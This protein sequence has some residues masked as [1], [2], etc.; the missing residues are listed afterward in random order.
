MLVTETATWLLILFNGSIRT[1]VE[2]RLSCIL[3]FHIF[4]AQRTYEQAKLASMLDQV[5]NFSDLVISAHFLL[6][7]ILDSFMQNMVI[8]LFT[9]SGIKSMCFFFWLIVASF[10]SCKNRKDTDIWEDLK[11]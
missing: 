5:G 6:F 4:F 3:I 8:F 7:S 9:V 2:L 11:M 10:P 1:L